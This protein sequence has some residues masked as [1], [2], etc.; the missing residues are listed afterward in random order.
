M[1]T[2]RT[3]RRPLPERIERALQAETLAEMAL[4]LAQWPLAELELLERDL[5]EEARE[6]LTTQQTAWRLER[7]GLCAKHQ[8]DLDDLYSRIQS[9]TLTLYRAV[10]DVIEKTI[11]LL[12]HPERRPQ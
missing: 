2:T 9:R 4:N 7:A 11:Y 12:R 3:N 5:R 10:A 8:A 1:T 6:T